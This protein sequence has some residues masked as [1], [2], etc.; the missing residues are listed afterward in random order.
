MAIGRREGS[1][2]ELTF[3]MVELGEGMITNVPVPEEHAELT[4]AQMGPDIFGVDCQACKRGAW[5]DGI[6]PEPD[7]EGNRNCSWDQ[8]VRGEKVNSHH[9]AAWN[10]ERM[11]K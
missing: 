6:S 1:A 8:D 3:C 9:A 4:S 7:C 2:L 10:R 11:P 5:K